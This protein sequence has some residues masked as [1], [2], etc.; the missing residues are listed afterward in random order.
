MRQIPFAFSTSALLVSF[1]CT[2]TWS[3]AAS[4]DPPAKPPR[5]VIA[6][7]A[8]ALES[9]AKNDLAR[10]FLRATADLPAI[11]TRLVYHN[12][13]KGA[14][15]TAEEAEAAQPEDVAG[16]NPTQ[17]TERFYYFTRYGSPVAYMRAIDLA[18]EHGLT[19]IAGK[20]V[21]D[22][23]YGGIGHLRLLASLGAH[24]VGVEVDD[25]LRVAYSFPGD[26]GTIRRA[27]SVGDGDPGTLTLV[28]G[29]YPGDLAVREQVGGGYDLII[30]KNVLKR[31][32]IHPEREADPR[33][34]VHLGVDD[35]TFLREVLSAMKPG[36]LFIV[37]NLSPALS[38][39]DEPYKPWSDGRFPFDRDLTV[40]TGFEIIAFDANDNTFA[41][42]MA[43]A[44]GWD[45]SM[46]VE[47]DLFG[48]YTVLRRPG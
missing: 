45:A 40:K 19:S 30:S 17:I 27:A 3:L 46:D 48:S 9:L 36:G 5:E 21:L 31:G 34:L 8:K 12:R 7:D 37:Y 16:F 11:E 26:T 1:A 32:Y 6:D 42:D 47:K 41:R 28:H 10:S 13:A 33:M 15:M 4:V 29:F 39:P 38:K 22:Y 14:A 2:C 18:A 43:R 44:L 24:A 35:E 25:L 20:R 23:G